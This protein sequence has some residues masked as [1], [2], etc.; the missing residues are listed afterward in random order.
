MSTRIS[1]LGKRVR[2][3]LKKPFIK[4]VVL[5]LAFVILWALVGLYFAFFAAVLLVAIFLKLD[6][7]IPYAVAL[8]LLLVSALFAVLT[9][10]TAADWFA[11]VAFYALGIGVVLQVYAYIRKDG[12]DEEERAG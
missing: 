11:A 7:R 9:Y 2:G 12:A 4:W 8:T 6:C 3:G 1:G 10:P 5:V